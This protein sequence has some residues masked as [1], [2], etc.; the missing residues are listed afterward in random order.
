MSVYSNIQFCAENKNPA[1]LSRVESGYIGVDITLD[2]SRMTLNLS[3]DDYRK[4]ARECEVA[5]EAKE[6]ATEVAA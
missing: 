4:L 1:I 2:D 3:A 6:A 5:A